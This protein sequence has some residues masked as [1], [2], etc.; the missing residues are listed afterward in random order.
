MR[1]WAHT[2][3]RCYNMIY[4]LCRIRCPKYKASY[5][6]HSSFIILF[7]T[8]HHVTGLKTNSHY[9]L[10]IEFLYLPILTN[11]DLANEALATGEFLLSE[12]RRIIRVGVRL[13]MNLKL[14]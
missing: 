1:I 8:W 6:S 11:N 13:F 12:L 3:I 10:K 9:P 7:P 2:I 14:S 4:R 5:A